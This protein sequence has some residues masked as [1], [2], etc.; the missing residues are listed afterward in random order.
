MSRIDLG[1][2]SAFD[3]AVKN[4]YTGTEA[5]WVNDIAGAS[6]AAESAGES[7]QSAEESATQ[8]QA[9][10]EL[11]RQDFKQYSEILDGVV[12][13]AEQA[14]EIAENSGVEVYVNDG[15]LFINTLLPN[16]NEVEF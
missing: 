6:E 4:G 13:T 2:V 14:V 15:A 5:D 9:S 7:A 8:A 3:I 12:A 16:G 11:A 1:A 10:A